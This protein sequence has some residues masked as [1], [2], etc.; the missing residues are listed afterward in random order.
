MNNISQHAIRH[1]YS[2]ASD[3]LNEKHVR[4]HGFSSVDNTAKTY[5]YTELSDVT[6]PLDLLCENARINQCSSRRIL[7]EAGW[8]HSTKVVKFNTQQQLI[9]YLDEV[10]LGAEYLP[11]D[12]ARTDQPDGQY[13]CGASAWGWD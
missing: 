2:I 11:V 5:S 6:L 4:Y 10:C 9:D 8:E 12:E 3:D 13:W 1:L 7:S